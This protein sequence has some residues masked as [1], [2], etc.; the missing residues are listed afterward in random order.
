MGCLAGYYYNDDFTCVKC[1]PNCQDCQD[2]LIK[3]PKCHSCFPGT[4]LAKENTACHTCS[5]AIPNCIT[6]SI[7]FKS[8]R[9]QEYICDQCDN[10]YYAQEDGLKCLNCRTRTTHDVARCNHLTHIT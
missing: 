3:P 6:C 4:Q 5:D 7:I 9:K 10:G 2:P 1:L 8:A